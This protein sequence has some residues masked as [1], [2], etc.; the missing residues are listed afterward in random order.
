[1]YGRWV[2]LCASALTVIACGT[3]VGSSKD[4]TSPNE[5]DVTDGTK[6]G[7]PD[8]PAVIAKKLEEKPWEVVSNKGETYL[9][10]VFYADASQNEQIMPY[11]ID[12]HT[13]IDRLVYPTLGNPNLYTKDD[14]N[15]ELAVVLRIEDAAMAHLAPQYQDVD[16]SNLKR[17]VVPNDPE[18]GFAFF[19]VPRSA[20]D[21][22][23]EASNAVSYGAGT[24]VVRI[25][26]N[27]VFVN[28]EPADEPAAFKKRHTVRFLFKQGAMQRVPAGLYDVRFE[29]KKDTRI[30]SVNSQPVFEYQYN[31]VRVFDS[32]PDE[33]SVINITDTQVSVGD[34]YNN[35]TRDKL[36]E[37][38]QFINTTNDSAVRNAAFVTFNGDLHNGGS[39]GSLR[40]RPVATTYAE[41]SKAIV[42]LLKNLPV[43]IFLTAG[44]HDG[45]VATGQVPGAVKA[46]DTVVFDS[47]KKVIGDQTTHPWDGFDQSDFEAYLARTKQSDRLGGDHKDIF[48]GGF[49]RTAGDSFAS[50]KEIPK[51][52][53]NYILYDGFYQWQ[54]TYG[55]LYY[56]HK[57]GKSFYLSL[58]SYELRQHRRSGWG[59]YTVNYGGGMSDV[60]MDWLDR[61]L[62]RGKQDG[63]DVIIL[64]HHDPR[65]GHKGKDLGYYYDQLDYHSVQQSAINY[66]VGK[67]WDPAVCKL[68]D[69]ALSDEQ[70]DNCAHDGLQE[71]M[72]PDTEFDCSWE[73]RDSSFACD[74]SKGAPFSSGVELLK[75]LAG[76]PQVRTVLL[77]HTHYNAME[78]IQEGEEL[79]PGQF[80]VD[81]NAALKFA[82]LEV[83]NPIRGYA[84]EQTS[85]GASDDYDTHNV[86]MAPL[87]QS[88]AKFTAQYNQSVSGWSRTL[89][90]GTGPRELLVLRLVSAADLANETY[91]GGKSAMGFSVLDLTTKTDAR[92]VTNPQINH[93]KFFANTG[94]ATFTV[95]GEIDIDRTA[96]MKPHDAENPV[97]KLYDWK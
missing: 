41:E 3:G 23:T 75:R 29:M 7:S 30:V 89:A 53:R 25:Y 39:P 17:L 63:S 93:A 76:S 49:A 72:R 61:D 52:D 44:N 86:P 96:S 38:V 68:P 62:L 31:A 2:I 59:M 6:A 10:N 12:G 1:M 28:P 13:M 36:D 91:S 87:E 64:A 47:L 8:D 71:W 84:A 88:F 26:P 77:G 19:L 16:G 18:N 9:P 90:A 20:R 35:K 56:S 50:W 45:Y 73:Q 67:V 66:L 95:V 78:V 48:T 21:S 70:T 43:P 58:N 22:A 51:A 40:Q 69:W 55:P 4:G 33:H 42:G 32:E 14:V 65:G 74:P 57:F 92:G 54:K 85:N 46:V 82:T 24:D 97:E 27:S 81:G 83:V 15:D 34:L 60:Q 37:L 80:P 11:A 94:H 79:L 5:Q